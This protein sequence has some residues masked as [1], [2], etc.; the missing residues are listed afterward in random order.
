MTKVESQ[1]GWY[2]DD[3]FN[4]PDKNAICFVDE[5]DEK[6]CYANIES[7]ILCSYLPQYLAE[8]KIKPME[9]IAPGCKTHEETIWRMT[10]ILYD[11]CSSGTDYSQ[12][13]YIVLDEEL[14]DGC[15]YG[16][17]HEYI[18]REDVK[19]DDPLHQTAI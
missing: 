14:R 15:L 4:G 19:F 5:H 10:K 6:W 16:F 2:D 17:E 12:S 1:D 11:F 7:I 18:Y 9:Y 13:P 8:S 3:I